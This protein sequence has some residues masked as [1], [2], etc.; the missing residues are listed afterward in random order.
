M[1]AAGIVTLVRRWSGRQ[2]E[3]LA[4]VRGSLD[5]QRRAV[6]E[7]GFYVAVVVMEM[8]QAG[9]ARKIKRV[10]APKIERLLFAN[11]RFLTAA[12]EDDVDPMAAGLTPATVVEPAV[13]R[14]VFETLEE[15]MDGGTKLTDEELG[16]LTVVLKTVVDAL[17]D[18]SR[19]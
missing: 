14:C 10:K 16:R 6:A 11:H 12:P 2:A 8:F 4:F 7:L 5:R 18:A 9:P 1:D 13:L 15:E 3:L 19:F 17:H